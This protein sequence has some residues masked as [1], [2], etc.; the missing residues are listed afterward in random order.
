M[1]ELAIDPPPSSDRSIW[2]QIEAVRLAIDVRWKRPNRI[3]GPALGNILRG[4][5]GLTFRKLV[6]PTEYLHHECHPCP[7]YSS[8]NYGQ[9]FAPTP[10]PDAVRLRLQQDLPRPFIIEPPGFEGRGS[11]E[12]LSFH[13]TLFGTAIRSLPYF[14]TTLASLGRE[15]MGRDRV[16]FDITGITARHPAGDELLFTG[17][18]ASMS[19]PA[20][21]ITTDDLL[22]SPPRPQPAGVSVA[23]LAYQQVREQL[24]IST[25]ALVPSPVEG[26]RSIRVQ[27]LTPTLIRAGSGVDANGRRIPAREIR[28][29]PPFGV[30][31]RR[32]RDRLSSLCQFFG[33]PWNH[34]DFAE[35]GRLADAVQLVDSRTTWLTRS[36]Q[37]TRTGDSHALNGFIGEAVYAFPS[38]HHS[39]ALE[40]L[41]QFAEL[42][43]LGKLTPWGHGRIK[44][45]LLEPMT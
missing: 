33:T 23:A 15:G 34:P 37:S 7:L 14:V 18:S 42:I 44:V 32:L 40:P 43:H 11:A 2:P 25:R 3:P 9:L 28:D 31:I 19:L 5:V 4:A 36:R 8:C 29:R 27:F 1:R 10:P 38:K 22:A 17:S 24:G 45:R 21:H 39:A 26:G 30:I 6:C 16:P 12:S 35:L 13:L 41:L 20:R